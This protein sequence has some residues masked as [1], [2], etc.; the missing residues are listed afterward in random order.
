M[1]ILVLKETCF[2]KSDIKPK[3]KNKKFTC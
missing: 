3:K 2:V 1:L